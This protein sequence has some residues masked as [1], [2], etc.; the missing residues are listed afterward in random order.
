M[1]SESHYR[2]R[3]TQKRL[4]MRNNAATRNHSKVL[5]EVASAADTEE[6]SGEPPYIAQFTDE[7]TKVMERVDAKNLFDENIQPMHSATDSPDVNK[8]FSEK[9]DSQIDVGK[10]TDP[11]GILHVGAADK[12]TGKAELISIT[13]DKDR[14][15]DEMVEQSIKDQYFLPYA[16]ARPTDLQTIEAIPLETM[17]RRAAEPL[18]EQ[19]IQFAYQV[20]DSLLHIV[21][22]SAPLHLLSPKSIHWQLDDTASQ[23][24]T[25]L[26]SR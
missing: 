26:G 21:A 3:L 5:A 12:G 2:W 18:R 22:D 17:T 19:S 10:G 4:S 20:L 25:I 23:T 24:F 14:P 6:Q 15:T 13:N 1:H 11:N 8:E 9:M 7:H 16:S